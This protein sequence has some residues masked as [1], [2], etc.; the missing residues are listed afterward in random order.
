MA[1]DGDDAMQYAQD[2]YVNVVD[3]YK[4]AELKAQIVLTLNGLFT[5]FL[6]GTIVTKRSDAQ[7]VLEPFGVET[8]IALGLMVATLASSI[9]CALMCLVTRV[10]PH[11]EIIER[12]LDDI[13]K[14]RPY[15]AEM[16]WFFQTISRLP[17]KDYCEQAVGV[18]RD[19][20]TKALVSQ[21]YLLSGKVLKKHIWVN[22]AFAFTATTLLLFLCVGT[23]YTIR[24]SL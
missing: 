13:E 10:M 17:E 24:V 22:R 6:I 14:G 8:W 7:E 1:P 23:S 16:M 5:T 11:S 4:V 20:H 2:L 19:F 15:P 9:L 18:K 21:N 12:H 3:W